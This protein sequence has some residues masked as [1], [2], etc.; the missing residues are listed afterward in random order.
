MIWRSK[1]YRQDLAAAN[2]ILEM[3]ARDDSS[4]H[5]ATRGLVVVDVIP[6]ESHIMPVTKLSHAVGPK[7]TA[8]YNLKCFAYRSDRVGCFE[9]TS[10]ACSVCGYNIHGVIYKRAS[11]LSAHYGCVGEEVNT[12]Q[13]LLLL[14]AAERRHLRRQRR[15]AHTARWETVRAKRTANRKRKGRILPVSN[16]MEAPACAPYS[17]ISTRARI[18]PYCMDLVRSG[19]ATALGDLR[20]LL[21]NMW[22]SLESCAS[23]WTGRMA[24]KTEASPMQIPVCECEHVRRRQRSRS[25]NKCC[26]GAGLSRVAAARRGVH[27]A[28]WRS[29]REDRRSWLW[30]TKEH[31]LRI[32]DL[33]HALKTWMAHR[34]VR[35][36]EWAKVHLHAITSF[37]RR[38]DTAVLVTHVPLKSVPQQRRAAY[39]LYHGFDAHSSL[40]RFF[41]SA[42]FRGASIMW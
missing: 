9:D 42:V 34:C 19:V 11:G 31:G 39:A 26:R 16:Q 15:A 38:T 20:K 36:A 23:C 24:H 5:T 7:R 1:E 10:T 3:I 13:Q 12:H 22:S 21:W 6:L 33:S 2:R 17:G 14:D 28:R 29:V 18:R 40:W 27:L 25:W 41:H 4:P 37:A 32:P 8:P 30:E 35:I